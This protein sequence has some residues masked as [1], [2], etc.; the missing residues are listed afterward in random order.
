MTVG[1]KIV[2]VSSA[3]VLLS[4]VV[5]LVVQRMTVRSQGIELT[6]N[7][8][9]AAVISAESMRASMAA[10]RVRHSFDEAAMEQEAKHATDFRQTS[11]YDTVPVVAAWKSIEKVARQEGFEFRVPKRHARD[12][13]NEPT[14]TEAAI[15]DSLEK[16]GQEEYFLSDRAANLIVYARPVRLTQDCLNCHGDPA[17][18]PTHDGKDVLG[19]PMEDWHEGEVHGAFVLTAHLDQVDHVASARAQAAAMQT[20]LLWMLP[21]GLLIGAFFSWYS[22]KSIVRPLLD[23]IQ[24]TRTSSSETAGAS[25]QIA[26]ASQSL[27]ES[28]TEQAASLD[29]ITGSMADVT[30]KTRKAADGAQRAKLL[31]DET[32]AAAVRGVADMTRMEQAMGEIRAATESVSTIVKTIDEVAFQTNILALNAAVEA[33][34]AGEAGLGFAVVA[35]EVRN[36]AQRSAEAA[37]Q[38]TTL[39]TDAL[40]RTLRGSEICSHA[41]ARFKEIE[42]RGKPLNEAMGAIAY[43]SGEQRSHIERV[44]TSV[45]ELNQ[46][47]QGV[48]AHAEESAAAATE[49]NAQSEHLMDVIEALSTLVGAEA[50]E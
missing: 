7:T 2:L 31:A 49:L 39:V 10:L 22:R 36:L 6:R 34:R 45:A 40:Q 25:R 5:A 13:R 35:D 19:F 9:R 15:L 14:P 30:E 8:M 42:N 17:N 27:A 44:T 46:A 24:S 3:S 12:P 43:A 28:A 18:S 1:R 23:V 38:T 37:R 26:A 47:T 41:V 21:A 48:A 16:S 50:H 29:G 32:S 4:T 33:A 20:T 11:L